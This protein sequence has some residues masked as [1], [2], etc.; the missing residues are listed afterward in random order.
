MSLWRL[1]SIFGILII[2]GAVIAARLFLLQVIEADF[3][4]ALSKGQNINFEENIEPRGSI[5]LQDLAKLHHFF[6]AVTEDK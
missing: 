3:Y 6:A 2:A 4:S 5:A 1:Y